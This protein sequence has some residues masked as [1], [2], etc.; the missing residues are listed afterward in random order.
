[1]SKKERKSFIEATSPGNLV[2]QVVATPFIPGSPFLR[3]EAK[4]EIIK[5]SVIPGDDFSQRKLND[6]YLVSENKKMRYN[7]DETILHEGDAA[8]VAARESAEAVKQL[9]VHL[10]ACQEAL[11]GAKVIAAT[12]ADAALRNTLDFDE[13]GNIIIIKTSK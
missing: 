8:E 5:S 2:Y 9:E 7:L 13:K 4:A 3:V 1:M 11:E 12:Y 6:A 10:K